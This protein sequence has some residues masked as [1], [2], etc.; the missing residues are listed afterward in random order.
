MGDDVTSAQTANLENMR[1]EELLKELTQVVERLER[2]NLSLDEAVAQYARGT[3]LLKA[4]Q[5]VLDSA[6]ARLE[7]MMGVMSE[8]GPKVESVS[9]EEF[10]KR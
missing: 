7:V 5:K 3:E 8:D 10:L 9:L 4:A 2:G 6:Q 1:F